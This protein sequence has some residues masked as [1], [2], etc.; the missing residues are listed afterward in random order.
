MVT[1]EA[2]SGQAGAF[3]RLQANIRSKGESLRFKEGDTHSEEWEIPNEQA[4]QE[5]DQ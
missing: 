4:R 5:A 1:I 2:T 3:P